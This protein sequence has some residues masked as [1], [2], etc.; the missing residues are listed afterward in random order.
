MTPEGELYVSEGF[1]ALLALEAE[2]ELSY[3]YV[4]RVPL[5]KNAGHLRMYLLRAG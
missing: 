4:G 3:E 5:A 1:A 2:E